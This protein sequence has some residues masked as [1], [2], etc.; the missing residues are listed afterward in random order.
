MTDTSRATARQLQS[1]LLSYPDEA[2][3]GR[4]PLVRRGIG[5]LPA[6]WRPSLE[7]FADHVAATPP[8]DLAA[9]YVTAFDHHKRLS[10][11]LTYFTQGDTRNRGMALLRLKNTYRG[12]GLVLD[13]GELPD[14]LSVVLEFAA[15][16]PVAGERVL[17]EFRPAIEL[18][19]AGLADAGSPWASVLDSIT[20]TLP[21]LNSRERRRV[22]RLAAAGPPLESVGLAPFAPPGHT[23]D[24]EARP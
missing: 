17:G 10:P 21:A 3:T 11:Y 6:S 13:G 4:L 1:L 7:S 12:A 18:L 9:G 23:C 20:E 5:T 8:L 19:R 22:A 15:T 16:C 14:H 2:L 24:G